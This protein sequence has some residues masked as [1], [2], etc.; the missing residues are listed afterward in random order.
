M[1]KKG[2]DFTANESNAIVNALR[3]CKA[4]NDGTKAVES[5][6]QVTFKINI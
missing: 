1:K 2:K 4:I 6:K 3:L 5:D